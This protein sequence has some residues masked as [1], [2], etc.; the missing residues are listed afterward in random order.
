MRHV[1]T[2]PT[3]APRSGLFRRILMG[4]DGSPAVRQRLHPDMLDLSSSSSEESIM[5]RIERLET[6]MQL[7]A[8]TMRRALT[9][10]ATR[11]DDAASAEAHPPAEE[12]EQIVALA[13]QPLAEALAGLADQVRMFPVVLASATDQ[14][15]DRIE[16]VRADSAPARRDRGNGSAGVR[17]LPVTPFELEPRRGG[18]AGRGPVAGQDRSA[19]AGATAPVTSPVPIG[20][21]AAMAAR[22]ARRHQSRPMAAAPTVSPPTDI[23][24]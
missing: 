15:T 8:E 2:R 10:L 14:V 20:P 22:L 4:G 11:I 7:M 23:T 1:D 9:R 17:V 16:S 6:G 19:D 5:A 12:V 21:P 13:L 18:G 24:A 3:G